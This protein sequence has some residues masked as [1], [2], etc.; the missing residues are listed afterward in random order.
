MRKIR[1]RNKNPP[2]LG[3]EYLMEF[4]QR[5]VEQRLLSDYHKVVW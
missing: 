4:V 2:H 1:R 3:L 5:F